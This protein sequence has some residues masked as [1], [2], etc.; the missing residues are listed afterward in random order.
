MSE[1]STFWHELT[2]TALVGT[3][4]QPLRLPLP[5]DPLTTLLAGLD[6]SNQEHALLSAAAAAVLYRQAGQRPLTS[7]FP[8]FAP[9]PPDHAPR[10]TPRAAQHLALMLRGTYQE[11]LSEWLAAAAAAGQ[12]VPE[13]HL[14][15]LLEA[16]Q[17]KPAL[18]DA[19]VSV[20]G[21]RGRWLAAHN[22][23]WEYAAVQQEVQGDTTSEEVWETSNAATRLALLQRLR[24][25]N[26]ARSRE[27][28]S[29]TWKTE[30]ADDRKRFLE[31]LAAGLSMDD[32]PFLEGVLDD[33]SKEV[34]A[35]AVNFLAGLPDSRL[36]Q[37]MRER[38][39]LLLQ[40]RRK[41]VKK[42]LE[43]TLPD[44]CDPE[45]VRDGIIPD[46]PRHIKV[47]QKTWWLG[48]M[49]GLVPPAHWYQQWNL[50]PAELLKVALKS[51]E[52][53][54]LLDAWFRAAK[55]AEDTAFLEALLP[56]FLK[57]KDSYGHIKVLIDCLPQEQAEPAMIRL[58]EEEAQPLH[59]KHPAM[60]L[61][62]RY[63]KPWGHTL[64]QKVLESLYQRI[65]ADEN[66]SS[67]T[68]LALWT[69]RESLK[70][71]ALRLPPEF[72]SE[73]GRGW[74]AHAKYWDYWED[75][76]KQMVDILNFRSEMLKEFA[77]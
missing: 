58:L 75:G 54:T 77:Q 14:V 16:G 66:P 26:P 32:E 59:G 73:V 53:E 33:R 60:P 9:C 67:S 68:R 1:P 40:F 62:T 41:I 4:R 76:V 31:E 2:V 44:A 47:G 12:R 61:L 63:E 3:G 46:V 45:M 23:D 13:E 7:D 15:S 65:T 72:V 24:R 51:E 70:E 37:R 29:A 11:V 6:P 69:F 64:A 19:M 57:R 38:V 8:S 71:F 21:E 25:V 27:L 55:R 30:K 28:L 18:R 39:A 5:G 48:Q 36:S 74:P 20:L 49:L 42:S 52:A 34:R 22:P 35:M 10:C 56:V 43:V 50:A 17:K